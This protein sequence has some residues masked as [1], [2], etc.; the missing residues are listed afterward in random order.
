M[1]DIFIT[2]VAPKGTDVITPAHCNEEITN[3][4]FLNSLDI[5]GLSTGLTTVVDYKGHRFLA[6]SA[7]PGIINVCNN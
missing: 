5:E 3:T 4:R 2:S 1:D 7:I 6:Q